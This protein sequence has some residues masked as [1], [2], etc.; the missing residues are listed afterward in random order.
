MAIHEFEL[1]HGAALTR[2]L[3]SDRPVAL[4]M[5]E[6]KVREAWAAYRVNDEVTLYLKHS[7]KPKKGTRER[8]TLTWQFT[9]NDSDIRKI[10]EFTPQ[11]PVYVVLVCGAEEVD[12]KYMEICLLDPDQVAQLLDLEPQTTQWIRV[13]DTGKGQLR[14]T[15]SH[16]QEEMKIPRNKLD[17]WA[18]PE[19]ENDSLAIGK[20]GLDSLRWLA[21][22]RWEANHDYSPQ[23]VAL[24]GFR[25]SHRERR[26][27]KVALC[28]FAEL[29]R[30]GDGSLCAARCS[31]RDLVLSRRRATDNS[32][33]M[34]AHRVSLGNQ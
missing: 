32:Y 29:C 4:R 11:K 14:V 26:S 21:F 31:F 30:K 20:A 1:F 15:G 6:T 27:C 34:Q 5:I 9:F 8:A 24:R 28:L 12:A 16:S 19:A 33:S 22:V 13:K 23:Y 25:H 3:R 7:K 2:L 17:K 10:A 18:V